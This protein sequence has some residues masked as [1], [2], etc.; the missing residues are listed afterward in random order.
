M[1]VK[2]S[3]VQ[4]SRSNIMAG[5]V[6]VCSSGSIVLDNA[7]ILHN[8]AGARGGGVFLWGSQSLQIRGGSLLAHNQAVE[9]G[10]GFSMSTDS[11][12]VEIRVSE[13][14]TLLN[15]S[16]E[17]GGGVC[18][19]GDMELDGAI[20]QGNQA[21]LDG[22]GAWVGLGGTIR[23]TGSS[24]I[25]GNGA[26]RD[27]GGIYLG[28][29]GV[30]GDSNVVR[31]SELRM[32][33][34]RG[35]SG[36]AVYVEGSQR[37]VAVESSVLSDNSAPNALGGA[38]CV[39]S[40]GVH[41]NL[42][43]TSLLRN[44][45]A[46]AGGAIALLSD[47]SAIIQGSTRVE[48]NSALQHG[49]AVLAEAGSIIQIYDSAQV[50]HNQ[51]TEGAAVS[52]RSRSRLYIGGGDC[53]FI[54]GYV[55]WSDRSQPAED[56]RM[57][58]LP[59]QT[60]AFQT[61]RRLEFSDAAGQVME[62]VP[63]A[64]ETVPFAYCVPPG[65]W[66]L[67]L[68]SR[69]GAGWGQES[70]SVVLPNGRARTV[71]FTPD[72]DSPSLVPLQGNITT[73]PI[74]AYYSTRGLQTGGAFQKYL[75]FSVPAM[76]DAVVTRVVVS[77]NHAS[78]HGGAI[79]IQGRSSAVV[80]QA[81][82]EANSANMDGGAIMLGSL[83]SIIVQDAEW[84]ENSARKGGGLMALSLS[85]S[86]LTGLTAE[87][88]SA[89]WGGALFFDGV[90]SSTVTQLVARHNIATSQGGAAVWMRSVAH[91][92]KSSFTRNDAA[93]G[94]AVFL[95]DTTSIFELNTF[96]QNLARTGNG[97]ALLLSGVDDNT[98]IAEVPDCAMPVD[99]VV[100][101][102]Q[103]TQ[104]CERRVFW[105]FGG[106]LGGQRE[107][108]SC[109]SFDLKSF[110]TCSDLL[111]SEG[112]PFLVPSGTSVESL[113]GGCACNGNMETASFARLSTVNTSQNDPTQT[114]K[115]V[116]VDAWAAGLNHV[117]TCQFAPGE[118]ILIEAHDLRGWSW[119][120]GSLS[121]IANGI[122]IVD[123][124]TI[125]G[126]Y[127]AAQMRLPSI[128]TTLANHFEHNAAPLGGGGA[129]YW[130]DNEPQG[131]EQ[132]SMWSSLNTA[133]YGPGIASPGR[134]LE[135]FGEKATV[136][137][138]G[139]WSPLSA[140]VLEYP[141]SVRIVDHYRQT[142][143][144]ELSY[145]VTAL[146]SD[147]SLQL[148]NSVEPFVE[149][150]AK[151]STLQAVTGPSKAIGIQLTSVIGSIQAVANTTCPASLNPIGNTQCGC[152][153]GRYLLSA[154]KACEACAGGTTS[155]Q[156]GATSARG[157]DACDAGFFR[158]SALE[159]PS[160]G[161]GCRPCPDE[162]TCPINATLPT[163]LLREGYWRLAPSSRQF[164]SCA[165]LIDAS[166]LGG[167]NSGQCAD[168][169]GG[170]RCAVCTESGKH[171][172]DIEGCI[173]CPEAT[174]PTLLVIA[175]L[176]GAALFALGAQ[177]LYTHPPHRLQGCSLYL[178][179]TVDILRAF[180]LG[181]KLR[182]GV[183]WYQCIIVMNTLFGV[184][185]P[186]IYT[187]WMGVFEFIDI[188]WTDALLPAVC[189]GTF[190]RRML[191]SALA[192]LVLIGLVVGWKVVRSRGSSPLAAAL[193]A[194]GPSLLVVF[195]FAPSINRKV[196]QT[197][198]CEPYE[199]SA[200]EEHLYMRASLGI[201][202]GSA[203]HKAIFPASFVLLALW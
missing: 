71:H 126:T 7:Q 195:L 19:F 44:N 69:H 6:Y 14:S 78:S 88:N 167:G 154:T 185:M 40:T 193:S 16:A 169:Y 21:G 176:T 164:L 92:W 81:R 123:H 104:R 50:V 165:S 191:F 41:I 29:A 33:V 25:A 198:D 188:D 108:V 68:F 184:T 62:V 146:S 171:H 143:A 187:D 161:E 20:L 72:A 163:L 74:D 67:W 51:A 15:N 64:G 12:N 84:V 89:R 129:V 125:N 3:I 91:V 54:Y 118:E 186:T 107:A 56:N 36:G 192:P 111:S 17:L 142:V 134:A 148:L 34:A 60:S 22:G 153:K 131:W 49:G 30:D 135:L 160:D 145:A 58:I 140:S 121:I 10:G 132:I 13:G 190:Q 113:C 102:Q 147:G 1:I 183:S 96:Q 83:C 31:D 182:I 116:V 119:W 11:P 82:M 180:G 157:C 177:R 75:S 27:G 26:G 127:S 80:L 48:G 9:C 77:H 150:I 202:C 144:A 130:V 124:L 35:G 106:Q 159:P 101:W 115:S 59:A 136:A 114:A 179:S 98:T 100:A 178:H 4:H 66:Q 174:T 168:G 137:A 117:R 175:A 28:G 133:K 196:F 139:P 97:G 79:S 76:E 99:I 42:G 95:S 158:E 94:G 155:L 8:F 200:A 194:L 61:P 199:F 166:C 45:S 53:R 105:G 38:I 170:P 70:M 128:S 181:A 151:Y 141:I 173:D 172:D 24:V 39:K 138:Y 110:A 2:N 18:L 156:D 52:C 32:N 85:D 55:D 122:R 162:V 103:N 112:L 149:G 87:R 73:L 46:S 197:W 90:Q 63:I 65:E 47:S 86:V 23:M 189:V 43:G 37:F 5:G 203:E 152:P 57:V 120:G 93:E 109:D 201:R